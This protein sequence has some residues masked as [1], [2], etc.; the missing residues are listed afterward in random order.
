M[1]R[2]EGV[3]RTRLGNDGMPPVPYV[4]V[5]EV[6]WAGG[7]GSG[8]IRSLCSVGAGHEGNVEPYKNVQSALAEVLPMRSPRFDRRLFCVLAILVVLPLSHAGE[9]VKEGTYVDFS[10]EKRNFR[11]EKIAKVTIQKSEKYRCAPQLVL[12]ANGGFSLFYPD[13]YQKVT[14]DENGK[15]I[16]N[17]VFNVITGGGKLPLVAPNGTFQTVQFEDYISEGPAQLVCLRF[18]SADGILVREVTKGL[19]E[20]MGY[21]YSNDGRYLFCEYFD[22]SLSVYDTQDGSLKKRFSGFHCV[23]GCYEGKNECFGFGGSDY[24][25]IFDRNWNLIVK[26]RPEDVPFQIAEGSSYGWLITPFKAVQWARGKGLVQNIGWP[27]VRNLVGGDDEIHADG[28]NGHLLI[29]DVKNVFMENQGKI[30]KFWQAKSRN[31]SF[32]RIGNWNDHIAMFCWDWSEYSSRKGDVKL[33]LLG[34][35]GSEVLIESIEGY[36]ADLDS[37]CQMSCRGDLLVLSIG[38]SDTVYRI[39]GQNH[40]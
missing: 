25:T 19:G 32:V 36:N 37:R 34:S 30:I 28:Y 35:E 31:R 29:N 1:I 24:Y 12:E 9:L 26:F 38:W 33:A 8:W 21:K 17:R 5:S 13:S 40:E 7:G 27:G 3:V 23:I 20:I 18:Y 39:T 22:S 10:G 14:F 4:W 16:S 2:T 6:G 15:Q 11:V